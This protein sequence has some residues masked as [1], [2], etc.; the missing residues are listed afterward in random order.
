MSRPPTLKDRLWAALRDGGAPKGYAIDGDSPVVVVHYAAE[1]APGPDRRR[2]A[3]DIWRRVGEP[4]LEDCRRI[5]EQDFVVES[6]QWQ[7]R[8]RNRRLDQ[9]RDLPDVQ[10]IVSTQARLVPISVG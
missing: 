5:L 9:G 7:G 10:C 8:A 3:D 4:G 2:D 6:I 1:T